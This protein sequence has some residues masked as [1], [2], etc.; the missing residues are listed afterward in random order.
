MFR[1]I[2][3]YCSISCGIFQITSKVVNYMSSIVL[4]SKVKILRPNTLLLFL[5]CGDID[6]NHEPNMKIQCNQC[7]RTIA[8]SHFSTIEMKI[9]FNYH[10]PRKNHFSAI[11]MFFSRLKKEPLKLCVWTLLYD[12]DFIVCLGWINEIV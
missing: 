6:P 3:I 7:F 5:L 11:C 9:D 1:T 8:K 12:F 10:I 2:Y 4:I